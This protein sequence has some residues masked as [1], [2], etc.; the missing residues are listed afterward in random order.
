VSSTCGGLVSASPQRPC[1]DEGWLDA[2]LLEPLCY[3]AD[4]LDRPADEAARFLRA[5]GLL[6]FDVD[7][8]I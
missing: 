6:F 7:W 1:N 2:V 8:F 4:F 5:G 3:S